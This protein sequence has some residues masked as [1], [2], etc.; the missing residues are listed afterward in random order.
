MAHTLTWA[1]LITTHPYHICSLIFFP[2]ISNVLILKSIPNSKQENL[3]RYLNTLLRSI[4]ADYNRGKNARACD[5]QC[6]LCLTNC[7]DESRLKR[8][9]RVSKENTSFPNTTV[10][11]Q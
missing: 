11:D 8:I 5:P 3:L 6:F 10:A 2:S 9:I 4:F 7:C 1:W